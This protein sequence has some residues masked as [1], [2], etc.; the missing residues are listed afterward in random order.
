MSKDTFRSGEDAYEQ[1]F[2]ALF[3]GKNRKSNPHKKGTEMFL[4]WDYG[5]VEARSERDGKPDPD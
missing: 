4:D 1:G 3:S 5:W 2:D